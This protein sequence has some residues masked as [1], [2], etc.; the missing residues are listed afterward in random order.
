[1]TEATSRVRAVIIDQIIKI[2]F[3]QGIQIVFF[4]PERLNEREHTYPY[5][6]LR[7]Q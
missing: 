5:P 2:G 7:L 1:M 4:V 6:V 3:Y